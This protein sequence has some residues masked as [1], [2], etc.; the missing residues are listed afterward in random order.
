M[1]AC[2]WLNKKYCYWNVGVVYILKGGEENSTKGPRNII[3]KYYKRKI[4]VSKR[5]RL[6]NPNNERNRYVLYITM[7]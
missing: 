7:H 1:F 3:E 4:I 2:F 6:L 5:T